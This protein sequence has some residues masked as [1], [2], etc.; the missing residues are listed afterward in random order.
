MFISNYY[1]FIPS[2]FNWTKRSQSLICWKKVLLTDLNLFQKTTGKT[3]VIRNS[4]C[5]STRRFKEWY[6]APVSWISHSLFYI[7][8]TRVDSKQI[9]CLLALQTHYIDIKSISIALRLI[10][11]GAV[12]IVAKLQIHVY[13]NLLCRHD[14]VLRL[15]ASDKPQFC[16]CLKI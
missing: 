13:S 11:W 4:T 6:I 8:K 16:N 15:V 1:P 9:Q 12:R 14:L 7:S 5:K 2:L 10:L 3:K